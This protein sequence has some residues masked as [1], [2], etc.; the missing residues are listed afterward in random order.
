MPFQE[1]E[2]TEASSRQVSARDRYAA[3]AGERL[4]AAE[5]CQFSLLPY[6]E[7]TRTAGGWYDA[8]AEAMLRGN[9][10][11]LDKWIKEHTK[12]AS[13]Q[14]F[15]LTD[16]LQL[17]RIC[18]QVAIEKEGWQDDHLVDVDAVTDESIAALRKQ[19]AWEIPEG[20][21]YVTGKTKAQMKSE[22]EARKAAAAAA[23]SAPRPASAPAAPAPEEPH[24][25]RR[26][27]VRSR[28]RMPILVRANLGGWMKDEATKTENIARGGVYFITDQPYTLGMNMRIIYPYSDA[29]GALNVEYPA[30]VVRLDDVN[31]KKGVAVKFLVTLGKK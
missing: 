20:L 4:R 29:P 12:I 14:G 19:V 24:G 18:R 25:E 22:E 31:G 11:K 28:I 8:A 6:E 10:S 17:L 16:L 21:N 2:A 3:V 7:L 15:E 27:T 9:Y 30:E 23:A 1:E 5:D 26:K 13:D